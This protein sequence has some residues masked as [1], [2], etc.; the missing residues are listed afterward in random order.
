MKQRLELVNAEHN[1]P[2]RPDQPTT[3][4]EGFVVFAPPD[5]TT[6]QLRNGKRLLAEMVDGRPIF[7]LKH[8]GDFRDLVAGTHGVTWQA[9]N[10]ES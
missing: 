7:R 9:L 2:R 8:L 3:E 4:A 6:A 10:P 5:I 1:T